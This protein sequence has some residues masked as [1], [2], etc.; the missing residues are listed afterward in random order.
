MILP[1]D[2]SGLLSCSSDMF[3]NCLEIRLHDVG[4]VDTDIGVCL[5]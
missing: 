5:G 1:V 2:L 3:A 4:E